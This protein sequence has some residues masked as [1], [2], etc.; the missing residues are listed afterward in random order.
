MIHLLGHLERPAHREHELPFGSNACET[1][2]FGY[3][4]G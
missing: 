1:M 3:P 4:A 2:P